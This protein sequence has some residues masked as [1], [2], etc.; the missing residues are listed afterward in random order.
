MGLHLEPSVS[1]RQRE[2]PRYL[3]DCVRKVVDSFKSVQ[4]SDSLREAFGLKMMWSCS[5][6]V[7]DDVMVACFDFDSFVSVSSFMKICLS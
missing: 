3:H 4:C 2:S 1:S 6:S 7:E 5:G